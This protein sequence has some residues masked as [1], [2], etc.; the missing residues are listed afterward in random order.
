MIKSRCAQDSVVS[1]LDA[2]PYDDEELT[3]EDLRAVKRARSEPGISWSGA[4]VE[5]S[6][7]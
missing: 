4:K 1:K 6:A 2:A 3:D 5:F 7:D